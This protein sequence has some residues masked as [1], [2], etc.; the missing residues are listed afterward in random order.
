MQ[1][2]TCGRQ[3]PRLLERRGSRARSE[4][5]GAVAACQ[6]AL[7]A[8]PRHLVDCRERLVEQQHL[9]VARERPGERDALLL[10]AGELARRARLEPA[11]VDDSSSSRAAAARAARA[12]DT[13]QRGFTFPLAVRC[14]N[15]A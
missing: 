12:S 9:R 1:N 4:F 2:R 7:Q 15:S 13:R 11:E 6:L 10:A 8:A 14:G 5:A 3:A